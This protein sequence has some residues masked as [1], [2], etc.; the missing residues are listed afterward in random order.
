MTSDT[1]GMEGVRA[2][3]GDVWSEK[4]RQMVIRR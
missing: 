3:R 2:M 4:D 1:E